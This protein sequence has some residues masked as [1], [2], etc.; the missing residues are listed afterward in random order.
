MKTSQ[1]FNEDIP[2]QILFLDV[3]VIN[4]RK[5]F[6]NGLGNTWFGYD[7]HMADQ[8]D[9]AIR[10]LDK[11]KKGKQN[12]D[13]MLISSSVWFNGG[14]KFVEQLRTLLAFAKLPIYCVTLCL[15]SMESPGQGCWSQQWRLENS[16]DD[17]TEISALPFE[18]YQDPSHPAHINGT[19]CANSITTEIPRILGQ[20][21]TYW[22]TDSDV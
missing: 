8:I 22:F 4:G 3:N 12:V 2:L 1:F 10:I 16:C 7:L 19:I 15:K 5:F 18:H 17:S 20:M 9:D 21:A 11:C 14:E 6:E 13:L